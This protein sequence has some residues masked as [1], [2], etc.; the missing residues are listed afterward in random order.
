MNEKARLSGDARVF[1]ASLGRTDQQEMEKEK[2]DKMT[3]ATFETLHV[4]DIDRVM[5]DI[6]ATEGVYGSG[7]A[8]WVEYGDGL[9]RY[10]ITIAGPKHLV[11]EL[12]LKHADILVREE[13]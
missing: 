5:A 9:P 6:E 11:D 12:R 8:E 7:L 4:G 1:G 3:T 10:A 2:M 13:D